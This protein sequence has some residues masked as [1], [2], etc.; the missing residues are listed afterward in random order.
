MTVCVLSDNRIGGQ[1]SHILS[2]KML[3]NIG[4]KTQNMFLNIKAHQ[5]CHFCVKCVTIPRIQMHYRTTQTIVHTLR[6]QTT[7]ML[8]VSQTIRPTQHYAA[9]EWTGFIPRESKLTIVTL[10]WLYMTRSWFVHLDLALYKS[11][12]IGYPCGC[13]VWGLFDWLMGRWAS[14]E[15]APYESELTGLHWVGS[16][17]G[18]V[19]L[20]TL[21]WLYIYKSELIGK[22]L[23]GSLWAWVDWLTLS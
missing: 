7:V 2:N 11:E 12:S 8:Y 22:H 17:W 13:S 5:R 20:L 16:V 23:V 15:L 3:F 14:H 6:L 19:K 21:S 4:L 1:S 18:W 10:S 9:T